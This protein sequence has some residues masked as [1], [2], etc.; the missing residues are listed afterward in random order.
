MLLLKAGYQLVRNPFEK[1][2]KH[3]TKLKSVNS[4]LKIDE[5]KIST[6]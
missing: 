6:F 5:S 3:K 4:M 2:I 1:D